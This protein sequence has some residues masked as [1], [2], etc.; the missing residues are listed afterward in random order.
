MGKLQ[1]GDKAPDFEAWSDEN[2][3]VRLSDFR[4]Q[5]VILYF[6]PKDNTTGCTKQSCLFR[7]HYPEFEAKNAIIFGI[8]PDNVN[9]HKKFKANHKLPFTLLVDTDHKIA[10]LFGVWG[11]KSMYGKTYWGIIRSHFVI[12]KEGKILDSQYR[13]S[14]AKSA[15][16]ALE[17]LD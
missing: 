3:K 4:G 7:D 9:S 6:Y 12:D 10:D 1:Q 13:V 8:S 16:K 11:K 14:P 17:Q 5:P 2:Q 15:S